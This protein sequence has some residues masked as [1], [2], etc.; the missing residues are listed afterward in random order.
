MSAIRSAAVQVPLLQRSCAPTFRKGTCTASLRLAR[1]L[2]CRDHNVLG[3]GWYDLRGLGEPPGL[4]SGGNSPVE[5]SAILIPKTLHGHGNRIAA[6]PWAAP[7]LPSR[8]RAASPI[9]DRPTASA[10]P[11]A[12]HVA[13]RNDRASKHFDGGCDD[14][15]WACSLRSRRHV[16]HQRHRTPPSVEGPR[17]IACRVSGVARLRL[18]VSLHRH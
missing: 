5:G 6:H 1:D 10:T 8:S 7:A 13:A 9:P 4:R 16:I 12:K 17:W 14:F 2:M 3:W 11:R 15:G 18:L